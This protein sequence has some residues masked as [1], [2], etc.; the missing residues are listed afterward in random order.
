M[1]FLVV[2]P[3]L[4]SCDVRHSAA[5]LPMRAPEP[6]RFDYWSLECFFGGPG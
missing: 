5:N 4:L 6:E 2:M 3:R 1:I